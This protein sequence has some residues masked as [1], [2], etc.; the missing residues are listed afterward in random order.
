MRRSPE[1]GWEILAERRSG[2]TYHHAG[3][4]SNTSVSEGIVRLV[5]SDSRRSRHNNV[6]F[7]RRTIAGNGRVDW[8]HQC[9]ERIE[10]YPQ[11]LISQSGGAKAGLSIVPTQYSLVRPG[12]KY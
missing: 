3:S 6:P 4:R 8:R 1:E 11:V 10:H 5:D 7:A 9:A 12:E 2:A